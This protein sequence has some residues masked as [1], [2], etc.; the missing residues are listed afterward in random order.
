MK[1]F[2]QC[3]YMFVHL[4]AGYL[5]GQTKICTWKYIIYML[6]G[7]K[8]ERIKCACLV[9]KN[10]LQ[11]ILTPIESLLFLRYRNLVNNNNNLT[12][13]PKSAKR[14]LNGWL[15]RGRV[16]SANI[17]ERLV[18][19]GYGWDRI[20]QYISRVIF[21]LIILILLKKKNNVFFSFFLVSYLACFLFLYVRYLLILFNLDLGI[22]YDALPEKWIFIFL[23]VDFFF[24]SISL[25][26]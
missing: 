9:K 6:F 3:T 7:N 19:A 14:Y 16:V 25:Y 8:I 5:R 10:S 13:D 17:T 12:L 20:L 26:I 23:C 2:L 18:T 1:T 21:S 24:F 15:V 22:V 4:Y 11:I